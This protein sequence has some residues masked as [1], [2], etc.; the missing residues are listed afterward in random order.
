M[1]NLKFIKQT[2][3]I[4]ILTLWLT[5][6]ATFPYA[7]LNNYN[8]FLSDYLGLTGLT[9]LTAVSV[10]KP[11]LTFKC[12]TILLV[13][14]LFNVFSFIY[15]VNIV[16]T[17]GFAAVVTPGVQLL[18]LI[19]IVILIIKKNDKFSKF[20]IEQFGQTEEQIKENKE[21]SK[22]N[23]K[24]K[25]GRLTDKEIETRLQNNLVDEA[26]QALIEIQNERK[27]AL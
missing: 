16:F 20:W 10:Y 4:I 11:K 9:I 8:L 19:L 13:L 2:E 25:F 12:L 1:N 7:I 6:L 22:N 17:F 14:G 23:F 24:A 27:N 5:I 15:F 21:S 26:R 18:S 3:N